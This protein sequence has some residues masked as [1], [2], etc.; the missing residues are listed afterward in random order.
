MSLRVLLR[1]IGYPGS[2]GTDHCSSQE[3]YTLARRNKIGSL[4][5]RSLYEAD[6]LGDIGD[7]WENRR[8]FQYRLARTF[9]ALT[10][11]IPDNYDFAVVK[12]NHEFW[13]DSKD[14]DIVVFR[15]DLAS[16][17]RDLI[18]AGYVFCGDSPTTFDVMH[19]DTGIQID[20]QSEFSLQNVIY[21][22]KRSIQEN[23]T[24]REIK[25]TEVPAAA[26]PDDLALIVIHSVT[27]QLFILKEYFAAVYALENFSRDEFDRFI[28]TVEAN[29]IGPACRAF[30]PLVAAISEEVYD[31]KP[32]YM[33]EIRHRY[34]PYEFEV[35]SFFEGGMVT[36]HRYT[37]R[38]GL[39]TILGK[40][41]NEVFLRSL[42]SQI[43]RLA[44]PE[45]LTHIGKELLARREREHYVHD[46][47]DMQNQED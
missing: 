23:V 29:D 2:E 5:V 31:R 41:G 39:R 33:S 38:T 27:E 34:P 16:L 1:T 44:N 36:P 15:G 43:P 11:D 7:K 17:K 24:Q 3:L 28:E 47:S 8:D 30:F 35:N 18:D 6:S 25:D 21:F 37:R 9:E 10:E 40:M 20:A 14:V 22:D 46:T 12:S 4:Y 13:A 42:V 26:A 32:P 45:T 19:P